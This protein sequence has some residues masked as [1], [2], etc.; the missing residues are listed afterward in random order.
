L[1]RV[2]VLLGL[3]GELF[4]TAAVVLALFVV[5][6]LWWTD[7]VA[8]R[9]Q[10]TQVAVLESTFASSAPRPSAEPSVVTPVP[11]GDAFAIVHIPRFGP[12][13]ARPLRQGV[14]TEVLRRGI[15]HYSSTA[16]PGEIGNVAIAGHRTTYGKPFNLIAT[17]QVGDRIIVETASDYFVYRMYA[18]EIVSPS[19]SE[20]IAPVPGKPDEQPARRL[21]TMTSCNPEFSSRERF[22]V[23]AELASVYPRE[24]GLPA[25]LLV[26]DGG[27]R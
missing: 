26:V 2:R 19:S 22:V 14:E 24:G 10:S 20:V 12:D 13:F 9:E 5:W 8:G 1:R 4:I 15:G 6:E 3:A 11:L 18:S 27:G 23:H 16:M 25:D 21:L 17:L 7:V